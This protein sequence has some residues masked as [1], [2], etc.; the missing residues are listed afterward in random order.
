MW[1]GARFRRIFWFIPMKKRSGANHSRFIGKRSNEIHLVDPA[2]A[3]C[4]TLEKRFQD[5]V[6]REMA[7]QDIA[8]HLET[9][10]TRVQGRRIPLANGRVFTRAALLWSAGMCP[11]AFVR[12]MNVPRKAGGRLAVDAALQVGDG[13]F[14]AGDSACFLR[15][16]R[17][18]RM[19]VQ[20]ALA[21]GRCAAENIVRSLHGKTLRDFRPRDPG[22]I[23]PMSHGKAC[24]RVLG[25]PLT[26]RLPSALHYLLSSFRTWGRPHSMAVLRAWLGS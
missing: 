24:G 6:R 26:G 4:N 8:L 25:L 18:L 3:P 5:Y 23:V 9:T 22:F 16:G 21:M 1:S 13:V 17:P 15:D 2:S 19:S 10:A 11:P 14:A 20:F 12:D 7:R